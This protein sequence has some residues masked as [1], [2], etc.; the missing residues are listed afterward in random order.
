M[1][2]EASQM[3]F[4][5]NLASSDRKLRT[6]SIDSLKTFI[7]SR[8]EMSETDA[9]KLWKG[10][11]YALWMTDRPLPQQA[12]ARELANLVHELPAATA[13]PWMRG[14][15][16][17]M[18]LQWTDID[19]LRMEKFLLLVRRSLAA[20]LRWAADHAGAAP[21]VLAVLRD[22]C[23]DAECDLR[24]VP[25]GLRLHALDIWV[26]ELE[27]EKL[28]G[29]DKGLVRPLGDMVEALRTCPVP[30]VRERARDSY[31]DERLPWVAK[32]EGEEGKDEDEGSWDGFE[33]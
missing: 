1:A 20:Q 16:G 8:K 18:S 27:R 21:D 2:G 24:K 23:F 15:W 32:E 19:V 22:W 26:D 30:T 6:A 29:E 10:L 9:L 14:F 12:L 13:V 4:I 3:P 33:D 7:G 28:L 11:Y 17:I 31:E 5:R 25:V